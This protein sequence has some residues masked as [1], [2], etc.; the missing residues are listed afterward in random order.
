MVSRP[1]T[2]DDR[3][4]GQPP[5]KR[6]GRRGRRWLIALVVLVLLLVGADFGAAAIAEHMISQKAR[7][8]LA[9]S[10]DPSVTIHG[11]PFL[12]QALAGDY[13]HI[14]VSAT[15]IPVDDKLRDVAINADLEDVTAPLSDLANGNTKTI[16]VGKLGNV[17]LNAGNVAADCLDGL[18]KFLL[19]T[20]R[21]EDVGPLSDEEFCRSKPYA[22]RT[23]GDDCRFSFQLVHG[24]YS[25][26]GRRASLPR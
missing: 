25:R 24:R 16:K 7:T 18:I 26:C 23:A 8:Q 4:F 6:R 3:G 22:R 5:S 1:V 21:D 10:D 15:G 13:S 17:A 19:A 20:A 12:T 9:L 2:R 14:S 11:F